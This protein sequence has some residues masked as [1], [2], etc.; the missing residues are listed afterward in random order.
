MTAKRYAD[1]CTGTVA[2]EVMDAIDRLYTLPAE[3]R[4]AYILTRDA[5]RRAKTAEIVDRATSFML[6]T[7]DGDIYY[8]EAEC[9]I[10]R[11]GVLLEWAISRR[12]ECTVSI[13][14]DREDED[15]Y[16]VLW[17]GTGAEAIAIY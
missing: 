13:Y 14:Q 15:D 11:I 8:S 6:H 4:K 1:L 16:D 12:D 5:E 7:A 3:E 10:H 9:G 17:V 2:P